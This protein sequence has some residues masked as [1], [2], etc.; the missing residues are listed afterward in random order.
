MGSFQPT[1][2]LLLL[3]ATEP[4]S[5]SFHLSSMFVGMMFSGVVLAKWS[6]SLG[7]ITLRAFSFNKLSISLNLDATNFFLVRIRQL[8]IHHTTLV[9]RSGCYPERLCLA[10]EHSHSFDCLKGR[11]VSFCYGVDTPV[12]DCLCFRIKLG[13]NRKNCQTIAG[14]RQRQRKRY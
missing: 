6:L 8:I 2:T 7:D 3:A 11:P 1:N 13:F 9:F 14:G 12:H 4:S 10:I 5:W